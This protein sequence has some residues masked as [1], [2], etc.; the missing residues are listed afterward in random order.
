MLT[1]YLAPVLPELAQRRRESLFGLERRLQWGDAREPPSRSIS[2]VH[3]SDDAGRCRS[4]STRCSRAERDA[5]ARQAPSPAGASNRRRGTAAAANGEWKRARPP[6][7][8]I[9]IDDF[10]KIDLRIAQIVNAEHVEGADKL[11]KLTLDVGAGGSATCSPAS[12]PPTTRQ[13]LIGR[14]T[15]MVA[16]LAPRKMKFG[17]SEGMVLA[18]SGRAPE[19][20]PV[21]AGRRREA[22]HEGQLRSDATDG[23]WQA[24]HRSHC[25]RRRSARVAATRRL[26]AHTPKRSRRRRQINQ[27]PPGGTRDDASA[28]AAAHRARRPPAQSRQRRR[29]TPALVAVI[30]EE[31]CIG[32]VKCLPPCPVDAIVGARKQM[33]TVIAALC[34]GCDL[35]V[36]PCPVDCIAMVPRNSIVGVH[37]SPER[38]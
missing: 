4:R 7:R 23:R 37:D 12:S 17:M 5:A 27:C 28:G 8:T 32:C 25:C 18:A 20:F 1:V 6:P 16:N 30:D 34:T 21:V 10:A 11:L 29:G 15:V 3:A 19:I 2:A 13:T 14:L 26:S 31:R 36:A 33:H 35:C 24:L 22:R 38:G 9:T